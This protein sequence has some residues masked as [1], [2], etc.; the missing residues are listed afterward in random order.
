MSTSVAYVP[1]AAPDSPAVDRRREP[2]DTRTPAG[3]RLTPRGRMTVLAGFI[4]SAFAVFI[5]IGAQSAAVPADVPF[6]HVRI[7]HVQ[8]GQTLWDI[9]RTVAPQEDPRAVVQAIVDLNALSDS[10]SIQVGEEIAI[11]DLR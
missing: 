2:V 3:V 5:V 10:G 9:A 1:A 8:S 7:V 11:P 6:E 4:A